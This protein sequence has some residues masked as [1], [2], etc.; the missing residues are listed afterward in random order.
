LNDDVVEI[1][2]LLNDRRLLLGL[3]D[4]GAHLT[5][6]CDANFS[7]YLLGYWVRE[8]EALS[9][10]LA[11]WRLTAHPAQLFGLRARGVVPPGMAADLVAFDPET[12]GTLPAERVRDLP[13]G[14]ERLIARSTGIE[15]IWVNGVPTRV[16]G[17]DL[18]EVYPGG[19]LTS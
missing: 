14:A 1:G 16:D 13:G 12:V 5:Q 6:L 4:A 17:R 19:V 7:T 15:H 10:E 3:S 11:I 18:A 9:L 2:R 8:R